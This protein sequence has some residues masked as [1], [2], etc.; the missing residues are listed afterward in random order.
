MNA[1]L[2]AIIEVLFY[3]SKVYAKIAFG[4]HFSG[5]LIVAY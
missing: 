2:V 4:V 5:L 3:L 1:N